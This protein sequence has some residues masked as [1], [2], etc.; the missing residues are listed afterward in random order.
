MMHFKKWLAGLLSVFYLSMALL[1]VITIINFVS[2]Q[3][4]IAKTF[5]INQDKPQLQCNGKCYLIQQLKKESTV[6]TKGI[7][8]QETTILGMVPVFWESLEGGIHTPKA[9]TLTFSSFKEQTTSP[10]D[11]LVFR[12]PQSQA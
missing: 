5:C 7:W 8:S 3:D 6:T 1:P 4:F 9:S 2:Q 10:H 12:P 11:A